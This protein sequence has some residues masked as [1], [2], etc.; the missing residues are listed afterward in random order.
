MSCGSRRVYE[1]VDGVLEAEDIY[2]DWYDL[3]GYDDDLDEFD[4]GTPIETAADLVAQDMAFDRHLS[5]LEK[6]RTEKQ[7]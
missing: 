5:S 6:Q 1:W 2:P 4:S 7:P 3:F